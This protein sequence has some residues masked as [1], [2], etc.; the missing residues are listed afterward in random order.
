MDRNELLKELVELRTSLFKEKSSIIT[1]GGSKNTKAIR[2]LRK[3]V[4]RVL[5]ILNEKRDDKK[6]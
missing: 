3:D 4:A 2:V 6:R 5:T 1:K